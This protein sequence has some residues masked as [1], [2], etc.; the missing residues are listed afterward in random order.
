MSGYNSI[1]ENLQYF[2]ALTNT[3]RYG[4]NQYDGY[5]QNTTALVEEMYEANG[6]SSVILISLS[7]GGPYTGNTLY[8]PLPFPFHSSP[9]K[10]K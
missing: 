7:M 10:K 1:Q 4:P 3:F 5:F 2:Q 8:P 9:E 6:N